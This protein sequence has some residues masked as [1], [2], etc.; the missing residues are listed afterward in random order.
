MFN[1][2]RELKDLRN[3]G[4]KMKTLLDAIIVV[5]K[6]ARG[7]VMVTINGSHE[8][9]GLEIDDAL[10]RSVI[11]SGVKEAF[12][13]ANQKLQREMMTAMKGGGLGNMGDML[14][15]IG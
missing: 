14:K 6:G 12:A 8:V 5:G 11:G 9:L 1:K 4:K 13:D 10:E 7:Q 3:Q 2:L 15:N